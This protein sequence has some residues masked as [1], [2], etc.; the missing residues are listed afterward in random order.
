MLFAGSRESRWT[1]GCEFDLCF[2]ND[3]DL[4]SAWG[5][6]DPYMCQGRF[7]TKDGMLT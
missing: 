2:I 6:L 1:G 4:T 7:S 3:L 5:D